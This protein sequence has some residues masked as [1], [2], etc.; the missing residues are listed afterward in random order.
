MKYFKDADG[1][2]HGFDD[3]DPQQVTLMESLA[4]A[5]GWLD[6]TDSW[7]PAPTA[8]DLMIQARSLRNGYLTLLQSASDRHRDEIDAGVATTLTAA[9]YVTLL[10]LKQTLRDV[11]KQA[12]FPASVSW[13]AIP[14]FLSNIP[15]GD[16]TI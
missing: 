6:V 11:T 10:A 7:P 5:G 14:D 8:N 3:T 15:A 16:P 9:Q 4:I 12:G 2:V 13:P 1:A